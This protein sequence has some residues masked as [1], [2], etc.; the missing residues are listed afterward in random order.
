MVYEGRVTSKGQI[1]IPANVRKH[2]GLRTGDRVEFR[3]EKNGTVLRAIRISDPFAKYAGI[4]AA[5][6]PAT[7]SEIVRAERLSRGHE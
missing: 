6:H 5:K 3:C 2:L 7:I 1:T 4:L